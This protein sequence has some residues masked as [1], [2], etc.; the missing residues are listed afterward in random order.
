MKIKDILYPIDFSPHSRGAIE[1]ATQMAKTHDATIHFL[2]CAEPTYP[3]AGP[4]VPVEACADNEAELEQLNQI[5]PSAPEVPYKHHHLTG[6]PSEEIVAFAK[7]MGIDLII[8]TTH[9]RTGLKRALMGSVAEAVV[10]HADC[11]VLVLRSQAMV[12]ETV[13]S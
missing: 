10:R 13:A 3:L 7:D 6:S 11:P 8:M 1:Y 12:P 2:F 5:I 9:G 4:Y